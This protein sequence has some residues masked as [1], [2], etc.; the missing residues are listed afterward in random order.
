[1]T[2]IQIDIKDGLSSSVAI[3]GPC[4]AAT[5]ANIT[6]SGEQTIDGVAVVTDDRVLVKNQTTGADNGIYVVDTG[7]WRRSKDFNKTK[8]IKTGTMVNVVS[9][10]TN[11]GWWEVTTTGDITVGTTSIVFALAI[12]LSTGVGG[13]LPI[14][15]GG[16]G[17]TTASA[18]FDALSP[19]TTRGDITFRNA[20]TNARLAASTAGYLL[21]TNGAGADPSWAGFLQAGTSAATRTWQ[22]KARERI[23]VKDFGAVGDGATNDTTAIQAAET[24]RASIGGELYFPPGDY[25]IAGIT[26]NRANGGGWRGTGNVRLLPNADSVI[27]VDATGAV[28]SSTTSKAF[29]VEG[30]EFH[31]NSHASV[32]GYRE[33]A[34]Y[35][36]RI[37]RCKFNRLQYSALF[38]GPNA[39]T[40]TGWITISDIDQ[41]GEGS[42]LFRGFDNTRYIFNINI[43][44]FNQ[45]GTGAAPWTGVNA[46]FHFQRAISAYLNNINAASLDG[47]TKGVYMQGD[48]QG[49]FLNNVIIG[50]PTY[51]VFGETW[52]DSLKPAYVYINN[53]GMDQPTVSG[54]D[55]TGRTWRIHNSNA[56]NGYLR[57]STGPGFNVQ[58][59]SSDITIRDTLAAYMN[60]DGIKVNV[61]A[62][63]VV[64]SGITAENNNQNAGGNFEINLTS[65]TWVDAILDGRSYIG[66]NG[67]NA[68]GQRVVN[69][70]TSKEV[71]RNTGSASTTAVT[72]Q[73]D[74]MT[75]SIPAN[76]LKAGQKVRLTA[77]GTTAANANGKTV[78]LWFGANSV[79]DHNGTWNAIPWKITA[80]IFILTTGGAA[81][82]EYNGVAWPSANVQTARQGT[83]SNADNVAITVKATGQNGVASA[84]DINCQGFTVEII[85]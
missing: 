41:I 44:N 76:A 68:T 25:L 36:T 56:T 55:I 5:T 66:S 19:N 11:A 75:Y 21:Q 34:P 69:G 33:A 48:C 13:T 43:N 51:G 84:G 81:T 73:E 70:T 54:Y 20:T 15:H 67:V 50:W 7:D 24:Y 12:S 82:Q 4:I 35:L 45:Q 3:K 8:D 1:M 61:G 22:D 38:T 6:L 57:S 79:I 83:A 53:C 14:A 37:S 74:L 78:R 17:Q 64:L 18:A 42:W 31:F 23:S 32:T 30:I 85:D 46:L 65:C 72:T 49:V 80:D 27:L 29:S 40:Q 71:S 62:S 9:G 59:T 52:T 60:H 47:A 26:V 63:K 10:S 2:S 58:A 39:A 77:W 28:I 16:T